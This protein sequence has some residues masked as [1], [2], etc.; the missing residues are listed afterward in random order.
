MGFTVRGHTPK[1]DKNHQAG[2]GKM[3]FKHLACMT[4]Q[5]ICEKRIFVEQKYHDEIANFFDI[6]RMEWIII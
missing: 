1:G 5:K 2:E 3:I 4:E 6:A